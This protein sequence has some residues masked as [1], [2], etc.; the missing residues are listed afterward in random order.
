[1]IKIKNAFLGLF[2]LVILIVPVNA[3]GQLT[4]LC[5]HSFLGTK[6][7]S[8]DFSLDQLRTQMQILKEGGY[9]FVSYDELFLYP[10]KGD[11]NVLI[12]LDDGHFTHWKA[13]QEVFKPMGIKPL[14]AVFPSVISKSRYALTWE[15]LKIMHNE[16][17]TIAAHGYT[18][19]RLDDYFYRRHPKQFFKEIYRPRVTMARELGFP[20]KVFVY[21]FGARGELTRQITKKAGYEYAFQLGAKNVKLPL[22]SNENPYD[23][24]RFMMTQYNWK[25]IFKGMM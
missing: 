15:Q 8:I 25:N 4:V 9:R 5:Y 16:G 12:T 6:R 11:K 10:L 22:E 7:F 24:P 19:Y 13:Y 21:P 17:C 2:I 23:L 1:M 18:H 20:I 14:L 3:A